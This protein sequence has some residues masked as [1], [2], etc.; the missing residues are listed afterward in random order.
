M[1][2]TAL[3]TVHDTLTVAPPAIKLQGTP[4]VKQHPLAVAVTTRV[5]TL[6]T[7]TD[8]RCGLVTSVVLAA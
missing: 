5:V 3:C 1:A 7:T 8:N 4:T 2:W 6:V